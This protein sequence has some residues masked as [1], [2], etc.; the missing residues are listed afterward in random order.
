MPTE[1]DPE[2]A[3]SAFDGILFMQVSDEEVHRRARN[4]KIDPLTNNIYHMED[5]PPEET[6]ENL[7]LIERLQPYENEAG[8]AERISSVSKRYDI[9]VDLICSFAEQFGLVDPE[10]QTCKV[11]LNM[12]IKNQEWSEWRKKDA[13]K[14][15][16]FA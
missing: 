12:Q 11:P 10:S 2:V 7:K 16:V 9:S 15:A 6:K 3:S 1:A 8:N 13:V 4:R 14:E 5:N